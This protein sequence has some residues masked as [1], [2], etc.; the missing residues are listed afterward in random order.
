MCIK[1]YIN[2]FKKYNRCFIIAVFAIDD[3]LAVNASRRIADQVVL[4]A[5]TFRGL[6]SIQDDFSLC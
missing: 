1:N 5:G 3:V 4:N 2:S 6:L